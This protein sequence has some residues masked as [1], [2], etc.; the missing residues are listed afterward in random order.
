MNSPRDTALGH[1]RFSGGGFGHQQLNIGVCPTQK[2]TI[3]GSSLLVRATALNKSPS[4]NMLVRFSGDRNKSR[5]PCRPMTLRSGLIKW[6]RNI[7]VAYLHQDRGVEPVHAIP[8]SSDLHQG[9][10]APNHRSS[11]TAESVP[12]N[13]GGSRSREPRRVIV[14]R[15]CLAS[16][17]DKKASGSRRRSTSLQLELISL[18]AITQLFSRTPNLRTTCRPTSKTR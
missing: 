7:E 15:L 4:G 3:Q 13:G 16:R 14:D 5:N 1:P 17:A 6:T 10:Q 8:L 2:S 12:L 11:P 9:V 18:P